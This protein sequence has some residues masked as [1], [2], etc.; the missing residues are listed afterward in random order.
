MVH[1]RPG[2]P[3]VP[4]TG[5]R[6][7][8]LPDRERAERPLRAAASRPGGTPGRDARGGL[9]GRPVHPA[10]GGRRRR[11]HGLA[12]GARLGR[13][14]PGTGAR[15]GRPLPRRLRRP[16]G[17]LRAQPRGGRRLPGVAPGR[18]GGVPPGGAARSAHGL[19][20]RPAHLGA[21]V[22]DRTA[23]RGALLLREQLP[24]RPRGRG[25]RRRHDGVRPRV[26]L[27]RRPG[28]RD[29]HPVPHREERPRRARA[30]VPVRRADAGGAELRRAPGA[31]GLHMLTTRVIACFD[32]KGGRVTKARRFQDNVDVGDAAEVARLMYADGVDEIVFYDITASPERRRA[33]LETVRAMAHNVF[34]PLTV[35]GG[36]RDLEDM[37]AVLAAGAEKISI[38]S[39]AVRNPA[40]ITA[41]SREFGRQC[42]VLSM[43]VQR[44]EVSAAVPSGYEVFID[45]ARV[46]TGMDALEWARRGEELG[47]G[48]IVV[49]S[50]DQDGTHT[51]YDLEITR[52]VA[53]AVHVTVIASGGAGT[54]EHVAHAFRAGASAAIVSSMLYSPRLEQNYTVDDIKRA[55]SEDF[56]L[57]VRPSAEAASSR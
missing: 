44:V 50:I 15:P 40:L 36:V 22:R 28:Q 27:G 5:D 24:R 57:P 7:D 10:R 25:R 18:G 3:L 1:R 19:E 39:M 42:M 37:H 43:Q 29:G 8:Q 14:P 17:A 6:R 32:V 41:G 54:P 26:R 31:G 49:N 48:E 47:A 20:R 23:A 52:A 38:D 21:P 4:L 34:V 46:A 51:G 53:D 16:P 45:G 33:D 11:D 2:T 9:G 30:A 12:A 13:A 56:G 35:G 55:L